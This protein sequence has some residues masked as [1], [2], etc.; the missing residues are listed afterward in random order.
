MKEITLNH[1]CKIEGHASLDLKIK[2]GKVEKCELKASEGARF[3]EALVVG[4]KVEDIQEIVSRICGIC[5]CAH[6]VCSIQ[7]LENALG[8]TPSKTQKIIRELLTLGERIRSNS[9]HL[10]FLTLPDYLGFPGALSMAK[11]HEQEIN[12]ALQLI[13]VGNKL[14]QTFGGREIHP[15]LKV[16]VN[17]PPKTN[18]IKLLE[19]LKNSKETAVKAIKLFSSLNYPKLKRDTDYLSLTNKSYANIEGNI[20]SASGEI[21]VKDYKQHIT[22]NIKEYATSKFGLF[23][24]KTYC[25]G[26]IARINNNHN[27]LNLEE[28]RLIKQLKISLPM[29]SPYHNN[30]AQSIEILHAINRAIEIIEELKEEKIETNLKFKIKEGHGISAIEAPRGTL[31]HEYKIDKTGIITYCNIITPTVQNLN[32]MEIDITNTVN[33]LLTKN[34][35]K[36]KIVFEIEKLIRSYD[37]CFSCST[38]FLKVKWF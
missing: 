30:I 36:E 21:N 15:F 13:T 38:H 2:D 9:T 6:T 25:V 11:K 31:F 4:K 12:D 34:T 7:A 29:T 24:G 23:D 1:I 14:I 22:E 28:K 33:S 32:Q 8:I 17:L 20:T 5:S 37:P 18:T 19:K 26:S 16:K 35:T 3:F 27:K 10:Y